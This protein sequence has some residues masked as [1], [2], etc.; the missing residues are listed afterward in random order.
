MS[1]IKIP[2]YPVRHGQEAIDALHKYVEDINGEESGKLTERQK[3]ALTRVSQ[4]LISSLETEVRGDEGF[5]NA[6]FPIE[7]A[8]IKKAI[9][10]PFHRPSNQNVDRQPISSHPHM[11][12]ELLMLEQIR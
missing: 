7:W 12:S 10:K 6:L 9:L 8:E 3:A 2:R 4:A 1:Y 5:G 11:H